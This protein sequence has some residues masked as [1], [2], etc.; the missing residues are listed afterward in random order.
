M[1]TTSRDIIDY[2]LGC[3]NDPESALGKRDLW[4]RGGREV[5]NEIEAQFGKL[6]RE[7]CNGGYTFWESDTEDALALVIVLDQFTRN[8]YRGTP[9]AYSGDASA[10]RISNNIVNARNHIGL[11][12]PSQIFLFH[13]FHHSETLSEQN[14]G[15]DLL[16]ELQKRATV[17]WH[18]YI[19]K[20]IDG[21][22]GHRDIV[23][24]FGRFP[25]RNSV[26]KRQNTRAEE[27]YLAQNPARFGQ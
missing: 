1:N 12:V 16:S 13:P 4:Y 14:Q 21:F 6:V 2:W 20:C 26:L 7:I 23:A 10:L 9:N 24:E 5:D 27:L 15:I 11:S 25:H 19:Q 18:S 17:E 8:L 22:R 3:T